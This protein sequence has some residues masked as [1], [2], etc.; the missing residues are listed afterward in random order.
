MK[1]RRKDPRKQTDH[2]FGV[3]HRETDE[4]IGKLIDLSTRGMMIQAILNMDVGS[5]YEI[6]IDLPKPVAE[7]RYLGFDAEC[8]WC[9][10]STRSKGNYDVGFQMTEIKFKEMETIQSLLN[11]A[12]FH[13]SK[14]QPRITLIEKSS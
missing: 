4:F 11:D 5:I 2:F 14:E 12:L 6:R 8:V 3:Y 9:R 1:E 10:E 13:D 7:K